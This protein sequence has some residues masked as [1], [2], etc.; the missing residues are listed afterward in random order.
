M[1]NLKIIVVSLLIVCSSCNNDDLISEQTIVHNN[2]VSS[3]SNKAAASSYTES[4]V[5]PK[6]GKP[7]VTNFVFQVYDVAGLQPLSVK[8]FERAT[9]LTT[10]VSM[11]RIGSYWKLTKQMIN[12]GW[13]DY[14]YVFSAT[15]V[16]IS[17]TPSYELCATYN[18]FNSTGTSSLRWPFGADG[19]SFSNRLLWIGA[20]EP[21]GCGQK[22]FFDYTVAEQQTTGHKYFSCGADDSY[23]EDW[24]KNCSSAYSDDGAEM[25]SPLDGQVVKVTIDS[26]TNHWGGY[27]NSVDIQQ[28]T[29]NGEIFIF[30]IAHLKYSPSVSENQW[31]KAGVTKLG[32]IGMSGGTSTAPHAHMVL[33]KKV[34]Q[35]CSNVGYKHYPMKFTINAN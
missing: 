12:N 9:G 17:T 35:T 16:A 19:S 23:A 3:L 29:F 20:R 27:G 34:I 26:S 30:R 32:N 25:R 2:E 7:N 14:R 22:W 15:N 6:F 10:Y 31:V 18:T 1:K 13:F 11:V 24:N 5:S 21:G 28:T 4:Q 8:F 33:Y